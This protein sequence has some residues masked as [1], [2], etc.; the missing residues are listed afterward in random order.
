MSSR[1]STQALAVAGGSLLLF[2]AL[3]VLVSG[4]ATPW[5]DRRLLRLVPPSN[6]PDRLSQLCNAFLI[7][8][9]ALDTAFAV[10][11]F[12]WLILR[13]KKRAAVFWF[14]SLVGVMFLEVTLK[15]VFE[16]E[17]IA[18]AANGYSFPS[19]NALGSMALLLS[20]GRLIVQSRSRRFFLVF[21]SVVVAAY[22]AALVYLSWHYP[23]DVVA[24]W[25]LSV[26]WVTFLGA[27]LRPDRVFNMDRLRAAFQRHRVPS[28][29]TGAP[30]SRAESD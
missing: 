18:D 23:S 9:M 26:A 3:A 30:R 12:L 29:S 4:H 7:S 28:L 8:G 20:T 24:G 1:R 21:G 6:E 27:V 14:A 19:G 15:P 13:R 16:R 5:P 17:P 2:A 10:L 22:G 11:V 25:L